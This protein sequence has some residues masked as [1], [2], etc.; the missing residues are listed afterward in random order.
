MKAFK[1]TKYD[2]SDGEEVGDDEEDRNEIC[3]VKI[4]RE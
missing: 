3:K 4:R 2:D 1:N